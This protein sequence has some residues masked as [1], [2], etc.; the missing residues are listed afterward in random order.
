MQRDHLKKSKL[1]DSD[2]LAFI[3]NAFCDEKGLFNSFWL[4]DILVSRIT[5][6]DGTKYYEFDRIN[7][8]LA[9][10]FFH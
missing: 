5:V 8:L 10:K 2:K 6:L 3:Y 4:G 9:N 7:E 1:P